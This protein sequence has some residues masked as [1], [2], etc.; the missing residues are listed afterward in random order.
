MR[1]LYYGLR[2]EK[3]VL[4]VFSVKP[5]HRVILSLVDKGWLGQVSIVMRISYIDFGIERKSANLV[6]LLGL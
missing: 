4:G 5:P 1:W 6:N 3:W 2:F